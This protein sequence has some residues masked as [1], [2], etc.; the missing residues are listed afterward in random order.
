MQ[1]TKRARSQEAK[2]E[3]IRHI[4]NASSDV[5]AVKNL[6]DFTLADVVERT[7]LSKPAIYNYFPTKE[8]ILLQIYREKL[9]CWV[10]D[11]S[12]EVTSTKHSVSKYEFDKRFVESF[13]AQ[14][15]L[16]KLTPQLTS[17]LEQNIT[18]QTYSNFKLETAKIMENFATLLI[19]VGLSNQDNG[20]KTALGY[21]T[22]LVGA[23]Q[24]SAPCPFPQN[25]LDKD[26]VS[27]LT[28]MDFQAN[29]LNGLS[30]LNNDQ[31]SL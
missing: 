6:N 9:R 10:Q 8:E 18:A 3:R 22:V 15:L 21:M 29:C 26:V 17:Q 4:I 19:S 13:Y 5:L 30:L 16:V 28:M 25:D 11:L 31:Q 2:Q 12:D 20:L 1:I 14:P 23:L 7:R 27:F 24:I